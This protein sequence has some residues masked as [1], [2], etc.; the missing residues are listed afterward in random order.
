MCCSHSR[1]NAVGAR[2]PRRACTRGASQWLLARPWAR[3]DAPTCGVQSRRRRLYPSRDFIPDLTPLSCPCPVFHSPASL[4]FPH[5]SNNTCPSSLPPTKPT[6]ALAY[7][8]NLVS[9]RRQRV[10]AQQIVQQIVTTAGC[11][12][13]RVLCWHDTRVH[14]Q[15]SQLRHLRRSK[16]DRALVTAGTHAPDGTGPRHL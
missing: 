5:S 15:L 8:P 1:Q 12:T 11:P 3:L 13:G 7:K 2:H 4:T 10:L 14:E 16:L 9:A 6:G